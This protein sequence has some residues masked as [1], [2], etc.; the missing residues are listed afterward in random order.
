MKAINQR[1]LG[2]TLYKIMLN[3]PNTQVN[4]HY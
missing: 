2:V 1:E 3:I 4:A